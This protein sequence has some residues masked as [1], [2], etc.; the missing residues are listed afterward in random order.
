[1]LVFFVSYRDTDV[2]SNEMIR[3]EKHYLCLCY[4]YNNNSIFFLLLYILKNK[5]F[6]LNGKTVLKTHSKKLNL[7][8]NHKKYVINFRFRFRFLLRRILF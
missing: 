5:T 1:M 8:P 6:Y 4:I 7:V 3:N 2:D